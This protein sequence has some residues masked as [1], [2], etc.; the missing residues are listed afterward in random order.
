MSAKKVLYISQEIFP[1]LPE[2]GMAVYSRYFPEKAPEGGHHVPIF[3]PKYGVINERRNQLHEV[4]RLSGINVIVDDSDHPLIIKV[5]SVPSSHLQVYFIDNDEFFKRKSMFEAAPKGG[6]DNP[7]RAI[8]FIRGALEAIK[9]LRWIPDVVHCLGW[10][11][12]LA[13]LYLKTLYKDDPALEK[14]KVVFTLHDEETLGEMGSELPQRMEFDHITPEMLQPMAGEYSLR[15][16]R[17]LAMHYADGIVVASEKLNPELEQD[18]KAIKRKP[19]LRL[20]DLNAEGVAQAYK[21]FYAS[22]E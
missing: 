5:A 7:E 21:D 1:Y 16:L 14:A 8:F 17:R 12:A 3:M 6:N 19:I 13:P 22:L 4:I 18:L 2:N 20:H 11:S 10:F 9:K 15:A